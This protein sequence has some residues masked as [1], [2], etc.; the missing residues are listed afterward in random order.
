MNGLL[1]FSALYPDII[2]VL[3]QALSHTLDDGK[4][5]EAN[6]GYWLS[7]YSTRFHQ[8]QRSRHKKVEAMVDYFQLYNNTIINDEATE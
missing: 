2:E 1:Y 8:R 6:K 7:S 3:F 4:F 5:V